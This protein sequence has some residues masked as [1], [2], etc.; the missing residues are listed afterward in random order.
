MA[1]IERMT[2]SKQNEAH[3]FIE[4]V[5][6]GDFGE[7]MVKRYLCKKLPGA[8]IED[9]S[10]VRT[11]QK[12]DIDLVV[13]DKG[14]TFSIEVKNDRTVYG[15]LFYETISSIKDGV[16]DRPGCILV[17][18]A[19]YLMYYYQATEV[20]IIMNVDKLNQWVFNYLS[21]STNER[22]PLGSVQN[23]EYR[24][25][26]FL[27]PVDKL[28]GDNGVKGAVIRDTNTN[29]RLTLK[30]FHSRRNLVQSKVESTYTNVDGEEGWLNTN[31]NLYPNYNQL[32]IPLLDDETRNELAFDSLLELYKLNRRKSRYHNNNIRS[33]EKMGIPA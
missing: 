14:R 33:R 18:E 16:I 32:D 26:G 31:R 22:F 29:K 15:N 10:G 30:K 1:I 13:N 27:I 25:E 17:T 5:K 23:K 6:V 20:V 21:N 12:A 19:D 3:E 28:L 2:G 4:D 8:E 11:Y 7:Y 24:A 9:K